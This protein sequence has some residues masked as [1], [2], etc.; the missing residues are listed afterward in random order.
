MGLFERRWVKGC[1]SHFG[2]RGPQIDADG[3]G[4]TYTYVAPRTTG[5]LRLQPSDFGLPSV[6]GLRVS[7]FRPLPF[8]ATKASVRVLSGSDKSGAPILAV[9]RNAGRSVATV[10]R[11]LSRMAGRHGRV[12]NS[13]PQD[14]RR[15]ASASATTPGHIRPARGAGW[16]RIACA[17]KPSRVGAAGWPGGN[18]LPEIAPTAWRSVSAG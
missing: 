6:F 15:P 16:R 17:Q 4:L 12:S 10:R 5:R 3:Q 13:S 9:S 11:G 7:D 8:C 1:K 2:R 18:R 14:I